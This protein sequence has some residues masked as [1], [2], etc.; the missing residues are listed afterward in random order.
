MMPRL[1]LSLLL[2][3]ATLKACTCIE[4]PQRTALR[5][6]FVVFQGKVAKLEHMRTVDALDPRTGRCE[7]RPPETDEQVVVTFKVTKV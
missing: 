3:A 1:L 7:K 6:A 5:A 4:V 2:A